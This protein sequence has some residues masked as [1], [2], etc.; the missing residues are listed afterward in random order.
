MSLVFA[1]SP[2][3]AVKYEAVFAVSKEN[4]G[5]FS[6]GKTE[7][8][9]NVAGR[10]LSCTR[11]SGFSLALRHSLKVMSHLTFT[12]V[13]RPGLF[14]IVGHAWQLHG[15]LHNLV[16]LHFFYGRAC[17]LICLVLPVHDGPG[18]SDAD[19]DAPRSR[20]LKRRYGYTG[21]PGIEESI[22]VLRDDLLGRLRP[23]LVAADDLAV[24]CH[25]Y[26]DPSG[27]RVDPVG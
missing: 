23:L 27:S 24:V 9:E 1:G 10:L 5:S 4:S 26:D 22:K 18:I 16:W 14:R 13:A 7:R 8:A 11:N 19:S 6:V 2:V 15:K 20:D 3:A 25:P 12:C 17:A 21:L